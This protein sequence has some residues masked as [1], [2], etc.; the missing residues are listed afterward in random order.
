LSFAVYEPIS[1]SPG[2]DIHNKLPYAEHF[3]LSFQ[4]E[5]TKSTVMTVSYVGTEGHRLVTQMEA[6]PGVAAFC[7]QLT[8]QGAFD[9]T[10]Q[11]VGC[12]PN[13]EQDTY[14][15]GSSTIYGT[16]NALLNPN[17]CPESGGLCFGYG[18]TFTKLIANS[19]YHSGQLTVQR[20]AGNVTFL[21]AYT[22]S[23]SLDDSSGF[24]DLVN[25]TNP[26]LSR[27]L[28]S[29]D[30]HQN[31]V[32][33]YMWAIPFDRAFERLPKRLTRGWQLQG[34]T[35]FASGIPV[36]MGQDS[37]D[38]S[39][40]GTQGIDMPNLV[41]PVH[42]KNP[43]DT[44]S[45]GQFTYFDQTA[46]APTSCSFDPITNLPS[47]DCGTFGT[48]NRRFF[49]GPGI[50]NTDLGITKRI[51]VTEQKAFEIRAEFFN[52]FNHAQ[53]TNPSGNISN[54]NIDPVTGL[55]NGSFGNITSARA[56]RIGQLSAK[57]FW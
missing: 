34:I 45:T 56:P 53:F 18:N 33:S 26:K 17:Y 36:R 1:Y 54:D 27:G 22:I 8:A 7:M 21:A 31:L 11:S 51:P 55:H 42:I 41:G 37:G 20:S 30:V 52:I 47:P 57:F 25:F 10:T 12:G 48:S 35:H 50:N 43:R 16:R 38:S 24:G 29:T 39:L 2:Y 13:G 19:V 46:F 6:N 15:L 14:T 9:Q 4:R 28:S 5:L 23:K 40:A 3:N 32:V 49:H 44:A